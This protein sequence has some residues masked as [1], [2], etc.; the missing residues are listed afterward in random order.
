VVTELVDEPLVFT[1]CRKH[2]T[3]ER[4][5]LSPLSC[6]K[7]QPGSAVT[8]GADEVGVVVLGWTLVGGCPFAED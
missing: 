4:L 5:Q 8:P 7:L 6:S 1:S 2:W 3:A